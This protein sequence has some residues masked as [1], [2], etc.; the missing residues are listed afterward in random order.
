MERKLKVKVF[1]GILRRTKDSIHLDIPRQLAAPRE[2]VCSADRSVRC[3]TSLQLTPTVMFIRG[4][5]D[6]RQEVYDS[7]SVSRKLIQTLNYSGESREYKK[8]M[9][10][11]NKQRL[12]T[13]AEWVASEFETKMKDKHG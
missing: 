6:I 10:S 12:K 7:Q 4:F 1:H 5:R 3:V 2:E 9:W 13:A 11:T 8:R